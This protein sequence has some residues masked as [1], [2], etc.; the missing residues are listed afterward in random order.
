MVLHRYIVAS[1]TGL[2]AIINA[3]QRI[4]FNGDPLQ[5]MLIE[6]TYQPFISLFHQTEI[7]KQHPELKAMRKLLIISCILRNVL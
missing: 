6:T 1:R 2:S 4:A 7:V 5:F 3:L